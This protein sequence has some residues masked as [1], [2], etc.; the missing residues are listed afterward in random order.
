MSTIILFLTTVAYVLPYL[1]AANVPEESKII[2]EGPIQETHDYEDI[3]EACKDLTYCT[4]R[5]KTYPQDKFNKMLKGFKGMA[6]PS[7]V[8]NIGNR[9]GDPSETGGCESRV[10]FE[11]LYTVR[12]K[13]DDRWRTVVQAPDHDY[14][15]KVRLETCT[16]PK[17]EC[18]K[19]FLPVF[20][21]VTFC[22]QEINT[23]EVLVSKGDNETELFR[24]DIP[25]CCS[26]QYKQL[27]LGDRFGRNRRK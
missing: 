3:P 2:Y 12:D 17:A 9:H 24:A 20:D 23:W 19:P 4:I 13:R 18:F 16:E 8:P 10:T 14:V 26:C 27:E 1:N 5:P 6:Q 22:N 11:P 15:Q 25:V 7:L 21:Y